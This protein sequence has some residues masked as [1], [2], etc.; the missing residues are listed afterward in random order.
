MPLVILGDGTV[1]VG[2]HQRA[3]IVDLHLQL[4]A[5]VGVGDTLAK[6]LALKD[7]CRM[8]NAVIVPDGLFPADKTGRC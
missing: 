6:L 2:S 1:A 8:G 7:F 5:D 3:Q 4:P